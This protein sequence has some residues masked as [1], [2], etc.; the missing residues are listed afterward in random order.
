MFRVG[1][2]N[3]LAKSCSLSKYFPYAAV[4]D[5]FWDET[6]PAF[7][8]PSKRSA[9]LLAQMKQTAS[10]I[11]CLCEVDEP[12][13]LLLP[14]YDSHFRPRPGRTEG[15]M[16]LWRRDRFSLIQGSERALEFPATSRV[17]AM[18]DLSDVM[19][20]K[21]I[22][23]VSVHLY[24]DSASPQQLSEAEELVAFLST[25][26]SLPTVICA[27]LNNKRNSLTFNHVTTVG[28]F[29]D[30]FAIAGLKPPE[31]T[32][33]VPDVWRKSLEFQKGR[34]DEI[35]FIFC[36]G[37]FS[38]YNPKVIVSGSLLSGSRGI[39]LD[40]Q[41]KPERSDEA[42]PEEGIPNE[43]HGSDHLPVVCDLINEG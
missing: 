16:I 1:Q 41:G 25:L 36:N 3:V 26:P 12:G 23:V 8:D 39:V 34:R 24:W 6:F 20:G 28:S 40:A 4:K 42:C 10:D 21:S 9:L 30:V 5:A 38:A 37:N 43:Y 27:D 14:D 2:F 18:V 7:L 19:T 11:L 29:R 33:L 35:D 15:C 17:A 13:L 22:R 31:F 32:S